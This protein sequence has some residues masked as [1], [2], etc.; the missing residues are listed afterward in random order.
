M[1]K[2]LPQR[3]GFAR[4]L[5]VWLLMGSG[6]VPV[7]GDSYFLT[8][9]VSRTVTTG[10][11][12][13]F[14]AVAGTFDGSSPAYQW[15]KDGVVIPGATTS[16]LSIPAVAAS[17]IGDY[18]VR[19]QG[20]A[21]PVFSQAAALR[22]A[23]APSGPW[24]SL[25]A[26]YPFDG[27]PVDVC[28]PMHP[29]ELVHAVRLVNDPERGLVADID[30]RGF[31]I[32]PFPWETPESQGPGGFIRIPRPVAA[33][34]E[35]FTIAFWIKEKGYSSWHGEAFLTMGEGVDSIDLLGRY[36]LNSL[37]GTTEFY[38]GQSSMIDRNWPAVAVVDVAGVAVVTEPWTAWTLV[39]EGSDVKVYREGTY[40]GRVPYALGTKGD[41]LIGSH[42]WVDGV[43]RYSTRLRALIDDVRVFN[44]ALTEAEVVQLYASTQPAPGPDAFSSWTLDYGLNGDSASWAADPD[45]DGLTNLQEY[46]FGTPPTAYT[47]TSVHFQSS[48]AGS[49]LEWWGRRDVDYEVQW[50]HDLVRWTA[51][52]FP[53]VTAPDQAGVPAGYQRLQ[54]DLPAMD[55]NDGIDLY[56]VR[57]QA[58]SP[59]IFN[60]GGT[61]NMT[62]ANGE[63]RLGQSVVLSAPAT[64]PVLAYQ[65]YKDGAPLAG[66]TQS[67]LEIAQ[68]T[69]ADTGRYE[70]A[71]TNA[72]GTTRSRKVFLRPVT[73]SIPEVSTGVV[74]GVTA[75]GAE[76]TAAVTGDGG[77]F[78]SERGV[79]YAMTPNP[80]VTESTKLSAGSGTGPF[81]TVLTGLSS[82]STYFLRAYAVNSH[83]TA[84]GEEV[85]ATTL[86]PPVSLA[87]VSTSQ[88]SGLT[89]STLIAGGTVLADGGSPVTARGL[90]YGVTT[91][92]TTTAG[93]VAVAGAGTGIFALT[94][95]GLQPET[96]YYIRAFATNAVG[97]SYGETVPV[98]TLA[99]PIVRPRVTTS[100]VTG[101]TPVSATGGGEVVQDGA[102]PHTGGRDHGLGGRR[103]RR[104]HCGPQPSDGLKHLLP[105]SL[106][107]QQCGHSV[108]GG[109]QL[110]HG[111]GAGRVC[112]RSW[113]QLHSRQSGWRGG[114]LLRGRASIHRHHQHRIPPATNRIDLERL[115]DGASPR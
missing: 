81:T 5:Y 91:D 57:V 19:I 21:G 47:G 92:P 61:V 83:G 98:T 94:L 89:S 84:Y 36:W 35:S 82:R 79:V 68:V 45:R 85:S 7:R 62:P 63:P 67:R 88:V 110:H 14:S 58:V 24:R 6:M 71:V 26:C 13:V 53:T 109:S 49:T 3:T 52:G 4:L 46:C 102:R 54:V 64:G 2:S 106:R 113:R 86:A 90:V 34:G 70:L 108:R 105:A 101:L 12:A 22:L 44:R 107:H 51:A 16:T 43:W 112:P 20:A 75:T 8:Q 59:P 100:A 72:A 66:A 65:W 111:G 9:P 30:G 11:P 33:E 18:S 29:A 103:D 10:Q 15:L 99:V 32:P 76:V 114:T 115:V 23:D 27:S 28:R 97:T 87:T 78:V 95:S 31:A 41:F 69:T 40:Q 25:V 73:E 55:P 37:G 104:L 56:A 17:Q 77:S 50:S 1:L 39:A 60:A 93:T 80:T 38:G 48:D 74:T 96:S 42:G